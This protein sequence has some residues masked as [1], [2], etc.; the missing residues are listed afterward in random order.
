LAAIDDEATLAGIG[1]VA[2]PGW[3]RISLY[4][5]KILTI[6][7]PS[8]NYLAGDKSGLRIRTI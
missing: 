6:F 2:P 3:D 5:G 8:S 7:G 4:F 1:F